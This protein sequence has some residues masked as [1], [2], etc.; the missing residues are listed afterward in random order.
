M[1]L[2]FQVSVPKNHTSR[3]ARFLQEDLA[4]PSI[5]VVPGVSSDLIVFRATEDRFGKI[6]TGLESIGCGVE[7]GIVSTMTL[8]SSKPPIVCNTQEES[9]REKKASARMPIEFI[10]EQIRY[11]FLHF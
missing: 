6:T 2:L 1:V 3:V 11:V 10:Y 8:S 5:T 7:Y 9:A 4:L